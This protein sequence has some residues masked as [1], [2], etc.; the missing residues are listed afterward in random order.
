MVPSRT[1]SRDVPADVTALAAVILAGG[2][3]SR[4]G[5]P[6]AWLDFHGRPLLQH[7]I[8]RVR[9]WVDEIVVVAAPGQD[10]PDLAAAAA[11]P[12]VVVRDD[13][14]G[15]GPLP[16]LTLGLATM[17]APWALALG[18]DAPLVRADIVSHL[19]G[20]RDDVDVV[21]P[22]WDGRPQPLV[23]LY[24]RRLVPTLQTLVAAGERRVHAVG[25]LPQVR[26]VQAAEL[27]PLDP[28]GETFWS[29]NTPAEY[30]RAVAAWRP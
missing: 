10:L 6:K 24:A 7:V 22:I 15:A 29:L 4:M 11:P 1:R 19:A 27:A 30:A 2:R 21:L 16:A 13:H 17:H 8:A 26:R 14:P 28:D 20:Q 5:R 3:S 12:P 25:E 23:A 9:P 18:C